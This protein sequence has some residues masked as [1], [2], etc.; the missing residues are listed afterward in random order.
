MD[1]DEALLQARGTP[2]QEFMLMMHTR[3]IA[4]ETQTDVQLAEIARLNRIVKE[5]FAS[6]YDP[7]QD[8][9][10]GGGW[11]DW[12]IWEPVESIHVT[13]STDV[14]PKPIK[15]TNWEATITLPAPNPG[16]THVH[17]H[18]PVSR[19]G[20][21]YRTV[22]LPVH[23]NVRE[24]F[25]AI[26]AFYDTVITVEDIQSTGTNSLSDYSEQALL[27]LAQGHRVTWA[28]LMGPTHTYG[29]GT[30]AAECRHRRC[31]FSCSGL[32]RFEGIHLTNQG[33]FVILGS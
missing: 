30:H 20:D 28:D 15:L 32:V 31:A 6:V 11:I 7:L 23:T 16:D 2:S 25:T 19:F 29:P 24:F 1:M 33:M 9:F 10:D 21:A 22:L 26:H 14:H 13:T 18:T 27:K 8:A 3:L 4:L 12:L 17:L 5:E